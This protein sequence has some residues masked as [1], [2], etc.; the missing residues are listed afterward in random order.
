MFPSPT[1]QISPAALRLAIMV[2]YT[3]LRHNPSDAKALAAIPQGLQNAGT[4]WSMRRVA[5]IDLLTADRLAEIPWLV[6]GF[7]TRAG[8][9]SDLR[10]ARVLNVGL[11]KW[12]SARAVEQNRGK[13]LRALGSAATAAGDAAADSFRHRAPGHCDTWLRKLPIPLRER[14]ARRCLAHP[15]AARAAGR[16]SRRLRAGSAGR[17]GDAC[18][19]RRPRRMAR[20]AGARRIESRGPHAPGIWH[21]PLPTLV[22]AIG[23]RN[24]AAR[25]CYEV[26]PEVAQAFLAQF[27]TA[28][29][30][31][32]G[33]F[34][35]LC[36]G[37]EPNF[38]PWLSMAPPG[39]DP[40]AERVQL[41]LRASNRWQLLDA[42]VPARNI[43]T[44]TI[45]TACRTDLL[46]SYRREGPE[47]GRQAGVIG[48]RA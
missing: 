7:S 39:H 37:E 24:W 25:L 42:G 15:R 44:S 3:G 27:A 17:H 31:F 13:L 34:D 23:P 2:R 9:A 8:G 40:P 35:R 11:T 32:D 36:Q 47:T 29:E 1:R 12:D 19:R 38:L 14:A 41:D 33:P 46:F 5:G 30:W 16:A 18:S 28:A 48:I 26:G 21:A 4:G 43:A 10:G 22:A 45:C 6:H 20:H